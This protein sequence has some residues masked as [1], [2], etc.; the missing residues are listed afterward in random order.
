[1]EKCAHC[2][3]DKPDKAVEL[4]GDWLCMKCDHWQGTTACPAC[5]QPVRRPADD[6]EEN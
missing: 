1:M 3:A 4:N 6:E 5:G 2:G